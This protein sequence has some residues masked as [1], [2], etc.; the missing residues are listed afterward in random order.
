[1][2][3]ILRILTKAVAV[4]V[5]L[6]ALPLMS[7][8]SPDEKAGPAVQPAKSSIGTVSPAG[9]TAAATNSVQPSVAAATDIAPTERPLPEFPDQDITAARAVVREYFR[10]V[11]ARDKDA[12]IKTMT[13]RNA[14][15][16]VVY[17]G[18]ETR[19]L[20]DIRY[21]SQ[22]RVRAQYVQPGMAGYENGTSIDNVIVFR[23][24][25]DVQLPSGSES[26]PFDEGVYKD[27]NIIL[28]RKDASHPWLIDDQG[29]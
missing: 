26:S 28:V 27:W 13:D 18:D 16:N 6:I 5:V 23:V 3:H 20:L 9:Y 22:D 8:C 19:T 2:E 10:A 14:G 24:S 7:G 25:F 21:D 11:E 29:Y 4:I 1:M 15:P 17:F 12:I